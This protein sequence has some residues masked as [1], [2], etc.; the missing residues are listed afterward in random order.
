MNKLQET[1]KTIQETKVELINKIDEFGSVFIPAF[2][3]F[4]D[5]LRNLEENIDKEVTQLDEEEKVKEEKFREEIADLEFEKGELKT[6]L[7]EQKKDY[8]DQLKKLEKE[9]DFNL[10][11]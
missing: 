2:R 8:Q 10:K 11:K 1:K 4:L 6:N 9:R 7:E 3:G 5:I